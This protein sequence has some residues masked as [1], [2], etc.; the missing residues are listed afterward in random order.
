MLNYIILGYC[1]YFLINIY[2]TI[3]QIIYVK[4]AKEQDAVILAPL[5]FKIAGNYSIESQ[6][7]S[8]AT[9][10]YDFILFFFWIGYGLVMLDNAT[11]TF[12]GWQKAVIF[13]DSFIIINWILTLPFS[14]YSTFKLDKKYKFSNMT[15][16][17]YI[18]DTIKSGVLFLIFGS[19][20]IVGLTLIIENFSSWWIWGFVFIF[21]IIILINMLYPLIRDK[22][23]DKFSPLED[24]ELAQKINKLL[25]DVGFKS[26][27][28]FSV[29][30]SK[31]DNRLNAYF[32]GLGSTK[33][34]V[35]FD[36]LIEKLTHNEIL[37]VLGHELGHFKNG[38]ILKNIGIMGFV[39][40]VF[41]AIFGNLP[42]E[43]FL[44]LHLNNESYAIILVFLI[45]SPIISFFLM[46]LISA[47]SRHNEYKA[48]EFGGNLS[49]KEDLISALL[50]L[51]NE[52]KS[53]PLSHPFYIFFHYS[54]PPLTERLKKLGFEK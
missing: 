2:V 41:F 31:R 16:Q 15:P 48:D 44:Q 34:V 40:F 20:A 25:E 13:I 36:T 28:V 3:I 33:R 35:L 4:K 47:M 17:L 19:G 9:A 5:K 43:L 51:A 21:A 29:D 30:A 18:K 32:G 53:F 24:K 27:G 10:F 37:A 6:K 14:L 49:S 12:N 42:Q 26:S 52:N 8:L 39:M 1:I 22:M 11:N 54:H 50:K 7:L 23:F 38:D 45:F 46:P